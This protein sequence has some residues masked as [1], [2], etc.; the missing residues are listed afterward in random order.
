MHQHF[1]Q[2]PIGLFD[3][4][5]VIRNLVQLLDGSAA[6]TADYVGVV[7][8]HRHDDRH[9]EPSGRVLGLDGPDYAAAK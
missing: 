7:D 6:R 9:E 3:S 2:H 1:V 5:S 4:P 8:R